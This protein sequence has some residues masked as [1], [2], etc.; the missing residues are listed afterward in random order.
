MA[1]LFL[2]LHNCKCVLLHSTQSSGENATACFAFRP[3]CTPQSALGF[4]LLPADPLDKPH[5][6]TPARHPQVSHLFVQS[7]PDLSLAACRKTL[8]RLLGARLLVP[9]R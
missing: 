5:T 2:G 4:S 7:I 6:S 3:I 9:T 1:F 8:Q